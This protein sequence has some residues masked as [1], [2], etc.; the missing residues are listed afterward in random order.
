M[1]YPHSICRTLAVSAAIGI[2]LVAAVSIHGQAPVNP[3]FDVASVKANRSGDLAQRIQP[4]P[5][6]RLTV[7]NVSLRGL[8]RFAYEVQDFQIA[9]GPSWLATDRFDVVG[10]AE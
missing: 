7:T 6:G 1:S 3:A 8:V 2:V 9:G 4:S 10:K 5:G